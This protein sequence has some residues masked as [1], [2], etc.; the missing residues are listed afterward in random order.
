[1]FVCFDSYVNIINTKELSSAR[2]YLI[3][4]MNLSAKTS[5]KPFRKFHDI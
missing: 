4:E 3:Y 2:K 1:M 5:S